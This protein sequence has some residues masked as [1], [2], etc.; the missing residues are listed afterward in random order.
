MRLIHQ[1]KEG[2]KNQFIELSLIFLPSIYSIVF[3]L[4]PN[5]EAAKKICAEVF[6]I[7]WERI[8]LIKEDSSFETE[9]E[10][11]AIVRSFLYLENTEKIEL[12]EAELSN[13]TKGN[14]ELF[15]K[16]EREFL[17]LTYKQRVI[18]VLNDKLEL[19][20]IRIADVLKTLSVDEIR[21]ELHS[22]REILLKK[23]PD[24]KLA[25]FP[26]HGWAILNDC[27][28]KLDKGIDQYLEEDIL[29][30]ISQYLLQSKSLIFGVFN[31][32]TPDDDIINYLKKFLLKE[33]ADE[34]T[35]KTLTTFSN[36][37]ESVTAKNTD[38]SFE[39][40]FIPAD[41]PLANLKE[42]LSG[43]TV[44]VKTKSRLVYLL[45]IVGFALV[46]YFIFNRTENT[47]IPKKGNGNFELNNN[48]NHL[49]EL[50][51]KSNISTTGNSEVEIINNNSS[52]IKLLGN[53]N[54]TLD[55]LEGDFTKFTLFEG[56]LV[57]NN[58]TTAKKENSSDKRSIKIEVNRAE[59]ISQK[60]QLTIDFSKLSGLVVT[61]KTGNAEVKLAN[62][63]Y[64]LAKDYQFSINKDNKHIIPFY[65][66]SNYRLIEL[67]KNIKPQNINKLEIIEIINNSSKNDY[68]TLFNLLLIS[69][70]SDR[71]LLLNKLNEFFPLKSLFVWDKLVNL[72][73]SEIDFFQTFILENP[74]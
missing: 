58:N 43:N 49:I 7:A 26:E 62:A 46:A 30:F 47:W 74:L 9:L 60:G 56:S 61:I 10:E 12:D 23:F 35:K 34:K 69:E 36:N 22:A 19:P 25:E 32:I 18:L 50:T 8:K 68:L 3:G 53:S 40:A 6:Y 21:E 55:K 66:N 72:E 38:V 24:G 44:P 37:F 45:L 48:L 59:I 33:P 2:R 20:T 73:K 51:E 15:T 5:I 13:I 39:K 63:T 31:K 52:K 29:E 14:N 67:I 28:M 4:V 54:L 27:L 57:I 64:Y 71:K 11:I 70:E 42:N 65:K 17:Q 16:V 1:A 41:S